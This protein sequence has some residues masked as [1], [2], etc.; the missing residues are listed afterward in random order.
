MRRMQWRRGETWVADYAVGL[1]AAGVVLAPLTTMGLPFRTALVATAV[2]QLALTLAAVAATVRPAHA[3]ASLA[4]ARRPILV[5]L[6][7]HLAATTLGTVVAIARGNDTA[8]LAGQAL[9]LGMLPL[10]ALTAAGGGRGERWRALCACLAAALS[11]G[12]C[13]QLL[14]SPLGLTPAAL[15][16]R[17][18]LPNGVS[19]SSVAVLAIAL[20]P[21]LLRAPSAALRLLGGTA[22]ALAAALVVASQTRTHLVGVLVVCATLAALAGA[23]GPRPLARA[24]AIAAALVLIGLS[25]PAAAWLWWRA[26]RSPLP[27]ERTQPPVATVPAAGDAASRPGHGPLRLATVAVPPGALVRV[28]GTL[29]CEASAAVTI[30]LRRLDGDHG[31][32]VTLMPLSVPAAPVPSAFVLLATGDGGRL[33]VEIKGDRDARCRLVDA[34]AVRLGGA[35]LAPAVKWTLAALTRPPD[36]DPSG[37]TG[38]L[39]GDA[40]LAFRFKESQALLAEMRSSTVAE[41]LLGHGLGAT[42]RLDTDGYDNRGNVVPFGATNYVHNLYLFLPFKLGIAGT[43]LFLAAVALWLCESVRAALAF[44]PSSPERLFAAGAAAVWTAFAVMGLAAPHLIAPGK[45]PLLGFLLAATAHLLKRTA[46]PGESPS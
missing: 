34:G 28:T 17:F 26:P 38:P 44:A 36:P 20:A 46:A 41:L 18:A 23:T 11:L 9:A 5:G 16:Q 30:R 45:A 32:L 22:I 40:S 19:L 2:L 1:A 14:G 21:C 25:L 3:R 35:A 8:L 43:A 39:A 31:A 15:S 24:S 13:V 33:A 7:L 29:A 27:V 12:A 6:A 4:A 37:A 42:F 10:A